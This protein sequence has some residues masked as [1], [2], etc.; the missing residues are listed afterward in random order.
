MKKILSLICLC[1]AMATAFASEKING[2]TWAAFPTP[3][4]GSFYNV[5][6]TNGYGQWNISFSTA[7]FHDG[8]G[9]DGTGTGV[10]GVF[11][12]PTNTI[13]V[14]ASNH[15]LVPAGSSNPVLDLCGLLGP[16]MIYQS[17]A[18]FTV[19]QSYT[20]TVIAEATNSI[21]V[22]TN[23]NDYGIGIVLMTQDE[24]TVYVRGDHDKLVQRMDLRGIVVLADGSS[25]CGSGNCATNTTYNSGTLQ[26]NVWATNSW[27]FTA[28]KTDWSIFLCGFGTHKAPLLRSVSIQG[29]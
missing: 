19:G 27:T 17:R 5:G 1:A 2:G 22:A 13:D 4:S 21:P 7:R 23:P 6:T 20:L 26:T 18:N 25:S 14:L 11:S 8:L 24:T 3:A 9:T 15:A 10:A 28:V 16:G 29:P 12:W